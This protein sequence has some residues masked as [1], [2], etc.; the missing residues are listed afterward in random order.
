MYG[1]LGGGGGG[2]GGGGYEPLTN[3]INPNLPCQPPPNFR[4]NNPQLNWQPQ[5]KL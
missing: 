4:R 1:F 2:A 5:P 3:K